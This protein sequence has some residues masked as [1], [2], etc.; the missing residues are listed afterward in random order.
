MKNSTGEC[1]RIEGSKVLRNFV[2]SRSCFVYAFTRVGLPVLPIRPLGFRIPF[3][4]LRLSVV[5]LRELDRTLVTETTP[6]PDLLLTGVLD[7]LAVALT[8]FSLSS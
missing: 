3:E 6:L 5:T 7:A 8:Q 1:Y 2:D 4:S